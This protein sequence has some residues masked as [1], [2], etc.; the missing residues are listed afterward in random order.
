MP[1]AAQALSYVSDGQVLGLGTGRAATAFVVALGERVQ[2]G[3]RIKGVP[4]SETTADL[5]VQVGIPLTTLAEVDGLD[6]AFD[7]ADE[8]DP[9]LRLIKGYGGALV[10]EKIV[11]ASARRFIVLVGP[12]SWCRCWAAVANCPSRSSPSASTWCGGGWTKPACRRKFA[13]PPQD[14]LSP[15][16]II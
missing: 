1:I 15:T 6:I 5:A 11:A 3:L 8:V 16:T 2:A 14:H 12:K 4:T 7:G 9:Q 13:R 10:R